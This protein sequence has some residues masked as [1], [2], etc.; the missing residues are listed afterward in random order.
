[1]NVMNVSDKR[2]KRKTALIIDINYYIIIYYYKSVWLNLSFQYN[3]SFLLIHQD[4]KGICTIARIQCTV[5]QGAGS[6]L[7]KHER[8]TWPMIRRI[9]EE[10]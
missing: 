9:K 10:S 7:W 6:M 2:R 4:Y 1:M 3:Y 5:L 8:N